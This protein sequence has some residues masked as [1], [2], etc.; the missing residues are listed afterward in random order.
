MYI[1]ILA[2]H[3]PWVDLCLKVL[4]QWDNVFDCNGMSYMLYIVTIIY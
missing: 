3:I 4:H 1:Y 2:S